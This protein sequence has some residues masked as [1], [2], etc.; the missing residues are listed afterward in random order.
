MNLSIKL[1]QIVFMIVTFLATY[2]DSNAGDPAGFEFLRT[3]VG[4]RPAAMSGAF[5]AIQGDI[6]SIHFNPAGIATIENRSLS[7]T[8]LKHVLDIHS[9]F[10]GYVHYVENLGTFG[11]GI[12]YIDYG[13]LDETDNV[14]EKLGTFSANTM[15]VSAVYSRILFPGLSGGATAKY[16]RSVIS[17]YSSTAFAFDLGVIYKSPWDKDLTIGLAALNLGS[18]TSAFIDEKDTL[19]MKF[20]A[21]ASKK[22]AHLPLLFNANVYKYPDYDVQ[23]A[24]GGEFTLAEGVFLRLG[25]DT[26]G[27]DQKVEGDL[28]RIAGAS[29]GFGFKRNNYQ[30]DYSFSSMGE[31]GS[32]NRFSFNT[33]F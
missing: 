24:L 21:G 11:A 3:Y 14:G 10:I 18:A 22:L 16:V 13:T 4:A 23:A 2:T 7:A 31:V 8:Y 33:E 19:P 26:I 28:D 20:V 1:L 29:I 17:S 30:L 5:A 9:G 27:R 12:N 25:Y 6:H 32:L 15:V